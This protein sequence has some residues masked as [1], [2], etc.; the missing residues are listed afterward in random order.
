MRTKLISVAIALLTGMSAWADDVWNFNVYD[1]C[2]K[3]GQT[4]DI[5]PSGQE[6]GYEWV[7]LGL[8]SGLKWAS[9]NVGAT[10]PEDKG[11]YYAWGEVKPKENYSWATYKYANGDY[12][13]L[14]KYCNDATY[15]DNSFTDTKIILDPED[16]AAHYN[17]GGNWRM[18]TSAEIDELLNN[19]TWE[20]TTQN[21]VNGYKVTSKTNGNSIFLPAAGCRYDTNTYSVGSYGDYWSS[22]L[23]EISPGNAW[24][25]DFRSDYWYRGSNF[26]SYGFS[27][28]PVCSSTAATS[29]VTLTLSADGCGSANVIR[30]NVG[31]QIQVT[32]VPQANSQFSK[33]NDDNTENPRT[34]TVNE[35][36]TLTAIFAT[37]PTEI[38]K[39]DVYEDCTKNGY[40]TSPAPASV[41]AV[42]LGLGV[43][44]ASCNVGATNPEDLGN[45]Y[46]WGEV[47]PKDDYSWATYKYANGSSSTLTKY[48]NNA[49]YGDN[50]FTD[51]KTT[52]DL[53][54]DAAHINWGG[55]WRMPT[56][57]EI[58]ELLNNCTWE[59]TTQ[60]DVTGYKV[61]SKA[62]GNSNSIFLP[63][64][65]ARLGTNDSPVGSLGGYWSSSLD[66]RSP[67][68][69][70]YLGFDSGDWG[71]YS[72]YRSNGFSVRPVC[73]S[74]STANYVTLTL[75]ADGCGS[76]NVIHCNVGQQIQVTAIPKANSQ[77]SKWNDDNT[78]NPRTVTVN[79]DM[80]LTAIFATTPSEIWKFDVYEDCSQNGYEAGIKTAPAGVEAVDLGL[81]IK[82]ASCNVGAE[83]PED[84]GNYY[85]WGETEAKMPYSWD[86]YKYGSASNALT[87]Y[88]SNSGSGKDG[89]TDNLTTLEASDDA[90]ANWGGNWRMP[91]DDEWTELRNNCFWSWTTLSGV[92]GYEVKASNGNSIF[93]PA[94]GFRDNWDLNFAGSFSSSGF[95][96]SSSLYTD[97]PN[98]AWHVFFGL[99]GVYRES[100]YRYCGQSVRPV[101]SSTSTT[102]YVTLTLSADGCESTNVIRCNAGQQ[103]Q[104]TAVPQAN[105]QFSKW[106]DD[107]T[108]NPRTVTVN[109]DMTLT[110]IFVST[111]TEIQLVEMPEIRTENGRIICDGEFQI[112]DLLGRNVTRQNGN[113]NGVYIVKCSDKTQKV[114]V[115]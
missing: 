7:N 38:W 29:Y 54:D 27:V 75:S 107:N 37:T 19:C 64:A 70:W 2:N 52:L 10:N 84:Y 42:D 97:N 18:P 69:A 90:A 72:S 45:Y 76:A 82:W 24:G 22:S 113:L 34:V 65:G 96:G 3:N 79:A 92:K 105:S 26:R 59:W 80:T 49:N 14:T 53:E 48:C 68:G 44:W 9:C 102:S 58:D 35:D 109:E 67:D 17:W 98:N 112:F 32:A 85:A 108:E 63:A 95:Y 1:N 39:F 93:L 51:D 99:T 33:W 114:V 103:V 55:N 61:T 46:A 56:S 88:C 30:C 40:E 73:S 110:A 8:P 28:R 4:T 23:N 87:K 106:N 13:K 5:R 77:F 43:K 16:D 101:C 100:Y 115:R 41:E 91:T 21:E 74:T 12:D 15:G 111:P 57:A 104:V 31:Q 81:S 20:W 89:F 11:N 66:E 94:A 25:L 86:T 36:M 6:N 78:E 50:S 47:L 83:K 71:R 62:N 60:N